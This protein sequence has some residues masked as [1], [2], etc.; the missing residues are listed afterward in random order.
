MLPMMILSLAIA[1]DPVGLPTPEGPWTKDEAKHLTNIRQLTSDYLRA[2]EGYF[3]PDGKQIVYQAEE[4]GTGNP[5]YQIFVQDLANG[6]ARRISPGIG[7][8]TCAYFTPD[9]KQVMFA[10]S[11]L[12][13]EAK[14]QQ[15]AEYVQRED[16]RKKG[17]RR[18]Y[19]WDFDPYMDIFV[20]DP[21]GGNLRNITNTK[22]YDAEGSF[23]PD[24]KQIVFCSNRDGNLELYIMNS[25]GSQ[26]RKLTNAPG[27]YNGG[28]FFSPD[29]KKV[30]FR[31][32]RKEKERLQLYVINTDG[33]G[34]K[35][36]TNDDQWIYWAPYWYRDSKHIIY[37]A[38]DHSNPMARPNYDLYWM[39]IE[40]GK[41][42]RLTH[43]PGQDVLPVFSPDFK[44]IMWTSSRDGRS[45]TQLYIADFTPPSE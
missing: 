35:A 6:R 45:P 32:D 28:P 25:D 41:T 40:T 33:T 10:S 22:G 37:T 34:E 4:K 11:H 42:A 12:D 17:V 7:R 31:S 14:K 15:Q 16:D 43:A 23:S 2:G 18:R 29:G 36:L 30:I 8:T 3:S 9:G 24:G 44:K 19:S 27:C 1:A 38:A 13:P 21:D 26:V 20:G 5:F 39:N